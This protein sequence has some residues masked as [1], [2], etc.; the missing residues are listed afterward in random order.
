MGQE[1]EADEVDVKEEDGFEPRVKS[2]LREES[3]SNKSEVLEPDLLL[4]IT[5][6][7]YRE[8]GQ[9]SSGKL[10]LCLRQSR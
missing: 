9:S 8:G 7:C 10:Q 5:Q 6:R 2:G 3:I 4:C 1:E